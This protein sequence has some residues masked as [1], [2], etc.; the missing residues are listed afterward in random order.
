VTAL[1][2]LAVLGGLYAWGVRRTR[3]P[4]PWWRSVAMAGGL[5]AL[6][7]AFSAPLD[8]A[9]D[10]RLSA[11]MVEHLLVGMVAPA[12]IAL[13]APVGL[14]LRALPSR[15]RRALGRA[16]RGPVLG[17]LGRPV[18]AFS[19]ATAVLF[20][21]HLSTPLFDLGEDV[22]VVH[23]TEH[24]ALFWTAL[25]CA[26][27]VIGTDPLPHRPSGVGV[28]GWMSLPMIAMA[29]IGAAYSSWTTVH[30]AHYAS[31][32]DQHSAGTVMWIG[33]AALVPATVLASWLAL[34]REELRQRRRDAAMEAVAG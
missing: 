18:V 11:H 3:R 19:L 24:A 15:P 34:W 23:A 4:W 32:A 27:L 5:I 21:Y 12:L 2:L 28:V 8:R 13:A 10:E 20:A 22:A 29:G 7:V 25:V 1:P 31:L 6:A 26:M 17:T 33:A 16:L 30:F 14:A 9:A